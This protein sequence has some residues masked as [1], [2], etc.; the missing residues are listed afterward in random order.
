MRALWLLALAG[1][2]G[3]DAIEGTWE[4]VE[5][6]VGQL[7]PELGPAPLPLAPPSDNVL[8]V[9]SWNVFRA[10]DPALLAAEFHAS[11]ELSRADVIVL[12][13][14]EVHD[15]E[16]GTRA[17]RLA[18][19]IGMTWVYAPA[20][21]EDGY[22]HGIAIASRYPIVN[23]RVMRLPEGRAAFEDVNDRNALA[24][25]IDLGTMTITV[26]DTH[27]DVQLGP[28]DRI[29][30]LHPVAT[31]VP[32]AVVLGGDFNTNPWAWISG[33]VPLT[34][35]EAIVGQD[36][37]TIL[38]DYMTELGFAVPIA[39]DQSTFNRVPLDH[40]RLDNVYVRGYP[41]LQQGIATDVAGSDHWPI[42]VDLLVDP[43]L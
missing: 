2:Y 11:A 8:R 28:I 13:E 34:S 19:A 37:A 3:V 5:T 27:L 25:E 12:Q 18:E 33:T 21:F 31:Q 15:G 40:M 6:I 20:R 30:Q 26:V 36:Q 4:P 17:R 23:A 42:W 29:R 35:T 14:L 9:A 41:V 7:A 22:L 38:D 1:C 16:D 39:P 10:P 24:A 32:D 43:V